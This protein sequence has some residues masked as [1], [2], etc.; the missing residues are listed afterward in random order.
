ME[1]MT[2]QIRQKHLQRCGNANQLDVFLVLCSGSAGAFELDLEM[3]LVKKD[4]ECLGLTRTLK[5]PLELMEVGLSTTRL[6]QRELLG[7]CSIN[8]GINEGS[9]V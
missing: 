7:G 2:F 6:S 3:N 4:G 1:G 8:W 5:W 9:Q